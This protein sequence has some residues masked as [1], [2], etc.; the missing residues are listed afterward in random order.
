METIDSLC[1]VLENVIDPGVEFL[2]LRIDA[3]EKDLRE[4]G[5]GIDRIDGRVDHL[6]IR[7]DH[8]AERMD[9][10]LPGW[11]RAST[12]WVRASMPAWIT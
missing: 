6:S 4:N 5:Q 7:A 1:R 12:P 10:G 8:L 9:D 2:R 11:M 3:L